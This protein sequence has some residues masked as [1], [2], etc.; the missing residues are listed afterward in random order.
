MEVSD[1]DDKHVFLLCTNTDPIQTTENLNVEIIVSTADILDWDISTILSFPTI[2][3]Q[4]HRNRLIEQSTYFRGL[5][6]GSFSESCLGSIAINWN[7]SEFLEILKHICDCILDITL[8]NFFALY[9]GALYFGVETL[10]LKCETWLSEVLSPEG[11]QSTQIKMEDLIQIWKFGSDRGKI[12]RLYPALMYGLPSKKFCMD[13][14]CRCSAMMWAKH[15]KSFGKLPYDLL[16]SSVKHPHLT[17]DSELHL[18]DALLLWL[19]SNVEILERPRKAEDNCNGILK[20]I[21][22]GLLPLWFALGNRNSFYFKQLAEESLDSILRL[23]N[24]GPMGSLDTFEYSDLHH[25]RI[26]LTEYSKEVD[27]SKCRNLLIEHAVDCFRKS[28][29]SL[30]ILKAAYLLNIGTI[31]FLQLLE[32]FSMVC[33]IDLTVDITPLIPASVTI[34]SS[35]PAEIQPVPEKTSTCKYKAMHIMSFNEFGPPLSIVTKL[36][37]E[38]RTDV[39]DLG[40]HYISKLCVSLR[41]LNIKGCIS[42]T[43]IGISDLISTSEKLNSIV[44]CETSF[45]IN[46]VQA[47]CSAI[48]DSGTFSS[49]HSRDKHLNSVMSN[50][51]TLHMGGCRGVSESSLIELMSQTQVLKNL[52]LRGTDL[53]DQ[54]LYNFVGSSLEMLDISNTKISGAALAYVIQGNPSLKCL[55][56]RDCRNLFPG[57]NC[58]EKR[59]SCF[60]S[61]HEQLHAGLGKMCRLE[62]IEFG[63]GFSSFSLSSLE[64][65]LMSLKTIN[66]GLGGVLGEDSLKRLP[67]ICPLLE[68]IILH[69]QVIS[70]IIVMNFVTSLENL[71]V[72]ALRYCFGDISMSSFKFPMQNLRKLRLERVTPWMTNGDLVALT[73]N[74]RNLVELSLLGCSLLD[75]GTTTVCHFDD[76]SVVDC[77]LEFFGGWLGLYPFRAIYVA[78]SCRLLALRNSDCG[79]VTANGASA[80]LDCKALEDILLRHNGPGLHRNFICYAASEMPLLRKLSLDI[81]D[82]RE[83]DFDI[84]NYADRYCLSTLKIARCKSQRCVFNL[85]APASGAGSRSVH[86]ETLVLVW[87]SR[88]LIKTVSNLVEDI[89]LGEIL[90][91]KTITA[92]PRVTWKGHVLAK[93]DKLERKRETCVRND[94]GNMTNANSRFALWW[95]ESG[96]RSVWHLHKPIVALRVSPDDCMSHPDRCSLTTLLASSLVD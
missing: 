1:D 38:G 68:T 64:S 9:E 76:C 25:L 14:Y 70:D 82:A 39:N 7:A 28:F 59:E 8:D 58:A 57:D 71:Q 26:R 74:C 43:D 88:D 63:W 15:S 80:L 42:V 31:Y 90:L 18:S 23:L 13:Q 85:P 33:E 69:F 87:N 52:C 56:A 94:P 49:L 50:F 83:R 93:R 51:E 47:L 75:P 17:V 84:P 81:C 46:S 10:L 79:E 2:K 45:G 44:V 32:K 29:P 95:E 55:K 12:K 4:A 21:R 30:R 34:L 89:F 86:M 22:V 60:P 54:A 92:T 3:V 41:H 16:L 6:S 27:I 5:L 65:A 19:E 66:L 91:D 62:E 48:S 11:F 72:L 40:L 20:Q 53:I 35:S 78:S 61:W 36:T 37:L 67:A 73:Q 96:K 77:Y 24:I